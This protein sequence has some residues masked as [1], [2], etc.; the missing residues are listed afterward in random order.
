M[1]SDTA[2]ITRNKVADLSTPADDIFCRAADSKLNM[3]IVYEDY[4][5]GQRA[6]NLCRQLALRGTPDM[7]FEYNLWRFDVVHLPAIGALSADDAAKADLV[8]FSAWA[9][10]ELTPGLE[11]WIQSWLPKK[12]DQV[13]A[14]IA[15]I[16]LPGGIQRGV[17]PLHVRLRHIALLARMAFVLHVVKPEPERK[18][19]PFPNVTEAALV[20][21]RFAHVRCLPPSPEHWGIN[22]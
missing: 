3:L 17:F 18:S 9:D 16:N 12:V 15:M 14:L 10:T 5:T 20:T 8:L 11:T 4:P 13:S 19:I 1:H 21:H 6:I 7:H 22:D 2:E